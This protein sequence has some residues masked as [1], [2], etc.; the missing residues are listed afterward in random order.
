MTTTFIAVFILVLLSVPLVWETAVLRMT[1][2]YQ[3]LRIDWNWMTQKFICYDLNIHRYWRKSSA[4]K[5][6]NTE[7][8]DSN[9]S[10]GIYDR[11][12][13]E[14]VILP[15]EH[16]RNSMIEKFGDD[17]DTLALVGPHLEVEGYKKIYESR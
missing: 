7:M 9:L 12:K 4:I 11:L 2:R 1:A 17:P 8:E 14:F 6:Y 10:F 15:S 3:V 5:K 13:H 16:W